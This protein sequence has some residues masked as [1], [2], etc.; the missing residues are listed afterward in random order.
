MLLNCV[1]NQFDIKTEPY[2]KWLYEISE[3]LP[4]INKNIAFD[5]NGKLYNP[6]EITEEM[7]ENYDIRKLMQ[8]KFFI[9]N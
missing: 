5:K 4:G 2:Y 7:Q 8:Y 1:I 3:I 9:D 6:K